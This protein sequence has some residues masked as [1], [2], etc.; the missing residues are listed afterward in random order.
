MIA[1]LVK[2]S[3]AEAQSGADASNNCGSSLR[4][5]YWWWQIRQYEF[6][7]GTWQCGPSQRRF[8]HGS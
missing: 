2:P 3:L 8:H 1:R 5:L 4:H 7:I 6:M